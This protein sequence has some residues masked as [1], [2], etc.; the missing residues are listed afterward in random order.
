MI[1]TFA[2][3][4][5]VSFALGTVT[6]DSMRGFVYAL[7]VLAVMVPLI[8]SPSG[9]PGQLGTN[10]KGPLPVAVTERGAALDGPC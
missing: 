7:L 6:S 2:V 9:A 5:F 10:G 4:P 1:R 3:I 8:S